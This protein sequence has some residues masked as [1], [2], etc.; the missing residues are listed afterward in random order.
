[1]NSSRLPGKVLLDINS[2]PMLQWVYERTSGARLLDLVSIATTT[3][4]SDDPI[5]SFCETRGFPLFRGSQY[6]VLDRY[7]KAAR[8]YRAEVVVR[9]TAD[10]PLID[11]G[12]IDQVIGEFLHSGAD[13]CAN[14]LPPPFHRTFPIGMDT[15]VA[16]FSAL[17][18][19]WREADIQYEREHVMPYLYD[20]EGRFKVQ[21]VDNEVDYGSYR[22]CV[23]TP[24]DLE[25]VRQVTARLSSQ[26]NFTWMDILVLLKREP[27]LTR[28]NS[29]VLHKTMVDVDERNGISNTPKKHV[30][31]NVR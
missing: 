13:F 14:R 7:Y 27:E 30:G 3:D 1:M 29:Q 15:E 20:Q 26:Q 2:K 19:A 8:E 9:I 25:F 4:P 24:E 22:W 31:G 17:E 18:R 28:I 21:V 16:S 10:C 23:D 5:Q 6:D 12:L 11:P